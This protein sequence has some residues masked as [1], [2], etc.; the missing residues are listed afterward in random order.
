[1][2]ETASADLLML[3]HHAGLLLVHALLLHHARL[4]V[5]AHLLLVRWEE[6]ACELDLFKIDGPTCRCQFGV[7]WHDWLQLE[8]Q[9]R[10]C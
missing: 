10:L 7:G 2:A 3:L 9:R 4:L 8:V 6:C 5:R 1:M